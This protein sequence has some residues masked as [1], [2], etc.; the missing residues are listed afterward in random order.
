MLDSEHGQLADHLV[1]STLDTFRRL[2]PKSRIECR[3]P[4]WQPEVLAAAKLC[5]FQE[6]YESH[7]MGMQV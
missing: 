1:A 5:G 2:S 6:E 4:T 3:I 7:T